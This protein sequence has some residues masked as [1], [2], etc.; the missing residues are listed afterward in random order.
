MNVLTD[1]P[2]VTGLTWIRLSIPACQQAI[3]PLQ[4]ILAQQAT[5]WGFA[6]DVVSRME[7]AT[8]EAIITILRLTY[9][10]DTA[11]MSSPSAGIFDIDINVVPPML[12][13]RITDY[14]LPYDLSMVPEFSPVNPDQ[15][16][17][18][19]AGLSAYLLQ[20]MVD[21]IHVSHPG[22]SGQSVELEW[23]LPE[24]ARTLPAKTS[25]AHHVVKRAINQI[26]IRPLEPADAIHLA[27][28]MY[29]NYGYSYVNPDMYVAQK[30]LARCKD[31]RLTSWI[32]S[33]DSG[34]LVGH[35]ALMKSHA[36][37]PVVEVGAAAVSPHAQGAGIFGKLF[38]TLEDNLK[39]RNEIVSCVHAV[40]CHPY[41]QKA[42]LHHGYRPCALMLGYI[43][44][45][46]QFRSVSDQKT[47]ERGSVYY[48][49]K[50][51]KPI[52]P[53]IVYLPPELTAMTTMTARSIG[54]VLHQKMQ[55]ETVYT[56]L[57]DP[58]THP[59]YT[60]NHE[61]A[62]NS[63]FIELHNWSADADLVLRRCLR[64]LCR[65]RID[66]IYLSV[67][68][69]KPFVPYAWLFLKAMGFIPS[70]LA[71]YL[72][73]PATFLLQYLNNNMISYEAIHAVGA[74][75][76]AIK[77]NVFSYYV[78]QELLS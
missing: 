19:S 39:T 68:L 59:V 65:Q 2:V 50:L 73:F 54:M 74:E 72:P 34:E 6:R 15:M 28:L 1:L 33:G 71:P 77:E 3:S 29:R 45:N 60:I 30:I 27:R 7:L 11:T 20:S 12:Q 61:L 22:K 13:L 24:A 26:T 9:G 8:E 10:D 70:G 32:A 66:V 64:N 75:A 4:A 48:S 23:Y 63:V 42:I 18:D 14:D 51:L 5:S 40:T 44:A 52:P 76:Q 62:L 67:D 78:E 55:T 43:P 38:D 47:D 46:L 17:D 49:C 37:S 41:T 31:G 16:D 69:S 56:T 25:S 53:I 35:F 57:H 58:E 36:T 21:A